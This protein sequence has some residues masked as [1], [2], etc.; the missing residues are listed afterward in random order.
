MESLPPRT[1][2]R[3]DGG[4]SPEPELSPGVTTFG[5]ESAGSKKGDGEARA[6]LCVQPWIAKAEG[7]W[8]DNNL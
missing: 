2:H 3:Y 1:G 7:I 6:G 4:G 8:R 5:G